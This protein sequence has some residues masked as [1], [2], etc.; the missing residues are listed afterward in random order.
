MVSMAHGFIKKLGNTMF[1]VA[2]MFS[3]LVVLLY[4]MSR[5]TQNSAQFSDLYAWLLILILMV[6]FILIL[7]IGSNL[8]RLVRQYKNRATGSRLTARLVVIFV[9]LAIV[10]VSLVYY[11]SLQ[12]LRHGVDSWFDV[13]IERALD[14]A[15]ELS[16]SALSARMQDHL[17]ATEE[18]TRVLNSTDQQN[19]RVELQHIFN[20]SN[21]TE[22]TLV[23]NSGEIIASSSREMLSVLVPNLPQGFMVANINQNS[24]VSLD[25]V[26]DIGLHI[27]VIVPFL[28]AEQLPK[29]RVLHAL[30]PVK[31]RFNQLAAQVEEAYSAY[32]VLNYQR[33]NLKTSFIVTLSLVLLLSILI[34]V[35]SA[36][37]AARR[38]VAPIRVLAIGTRAVAA[39]DYSKRLPLPSKDEFGFLVSSFNDMTEKIAQ[40]RDEAALSQK[41][42]ENQRSYLAAVLGHLSSGVLALDADLKVTTA[43]NAA[44]Q[45][46]NVDISALLNQKIVT[47]VEHH[48]YLAPFISALEEL[49]KSGQAEWQQEVILLVE[50][51]HQVLM[52]KGESLLDLERTDVSY[53]IVFDDITSLIQVQRDAA[54]GEVARRMAHEIKNPLT[55]IQLSAERLR[56]KYLSTMDPEDAEILDKSTHTI[57]QQVEVM[58]EMVQAF[59]EYARTP[60]LVLLPLDINTL[61]NEVLDLYR[62]GAQDVRLET[63]LDQ[64]ISDIE[65]DKGRVRQLLHNLIKNALEALKESQHDTP[66]ITIM[67]RLFAQQDDVGVLMTVSDNGAGFDAAIL[68]HIFEPYVTSRSKGT[69]LGLAI[70]KKIVEEHRGRIRVKNMDGGGAKIEIY[71]PL[72]GVSKKNK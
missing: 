22:L 8:F 64:D 37:I 55:P 48:A 1:P 14:D 10:P 25:I 62:G 42:I 18:M 24:Q 35:W 50:G 43:N 21:A 17:R 45:I 69:G 26:K 65:V 59:S 4:M 13:K 15:L 38:L 31:E 36:F 23:N 29:Q 32:K 39:G 44:A 34:A 28:S 12:F 16:R 60:E 56:H 27:R 71:F 49:G 72:Q 47:L 70:V 11:F 52:C 6:A 58:K 41:K 51:E 63:D 33:G 30:Y 2:V 20:Q 54:W 57:V 9:V 53:V 67:T 3:L 7:L 68:G 40:A 5:A 61:I 66:V 46:L 19:T